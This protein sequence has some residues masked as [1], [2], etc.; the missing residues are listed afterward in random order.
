MTHA[1]HLSRARMRCFTHCSACDELQS[2]LAREKEDH[3]EQKTMAAKLETDLADLSGAYNT[4]EVRRSQSLLSLKLHA[5]Q[6]VVTGCTFFWAPITR[7]VQP[8]S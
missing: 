1:R 3:E 4:L 6:C 5:A 2:D 8:R 7:L